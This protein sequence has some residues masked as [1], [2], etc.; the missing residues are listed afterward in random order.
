M[1]TLANLAR[2]QPNWSLEEF[3]NVAN[4]LLPQYLPATKGNTRV[5]EEINPRL[6][7]HYTSLGML[8]EPQKEGKYALYIYRHLLQILVVRRLLS[9]GVGANA[10]DRLAKEKTN[11]EL[12]NLLT[13]G[14]QL[15][16]TPSNPALA[17][18]Q[19]LKKSDRSAA[20][21]IPHIS[22][23]LQRRLNASNG[24]KWRWQ[25]LLYRISRTIAE[26]FPN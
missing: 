5:R 1:E 16:V 25:L 18:L 13:G 15:E 20:L 11:A 9:E 10:I 22:Q 2:S 23:R 7:R 19:Q 6:V 14:V 24:A 12:E 8:D 26:Y 17:Y 3:V 4:E 21:P